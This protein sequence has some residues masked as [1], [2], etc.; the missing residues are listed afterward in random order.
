MFSDNYEDILRAAAKQIC[1]YV[2]YRYAHPQTEVSITGF[3]YSITRA[4][5]DNLF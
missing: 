4:C 5:L 1:D 2:E 3:L